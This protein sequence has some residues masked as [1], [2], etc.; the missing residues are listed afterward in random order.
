MR[1]FL[2][3]TKEVAHDTDEVHTTM[4]NDIFTPEFYKAFYKEVVDAGQ[5]EGLYEDICD[6]KTVPIDFY[7][8]ENDMYVTCEAH[9]T[10]DLHDES[11]DHLF[12]T[13]HD[14]NPYYEVV[15]CDYVG[16]VRIYESDERDA[17]E[18]KG[19]SHDDFWAQFEGDLSWCKKGD[20]VLYCNLE[21]EFLAYNTER[22]EFKLRFADGKTMYADS[23]FVKRAKT[24]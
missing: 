12:G 7:I 24:A 11:F 6:G 9:Y 22:G 4:A 5:A 17:K 14:P 15:G 2:I 23:R 18:I 20:K 16:E 1:T 21:A 3:L 10:T 19:F 13:W 8:G